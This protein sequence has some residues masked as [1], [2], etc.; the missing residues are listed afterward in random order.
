M[1]G[2]L[3]LLSRDANI[4][5]T[6]N[7]PTVHIK[8]YPGYGLRSATGQ[9]KIYISGV[10]WHGPVVF[11]RRQKMLIKMLGGVM[12]ASAE[13]LECE[14]FL[15]R[16]TPFMAEC[17]TKE[18]VSVE[19]GDQRIDLKKKTKRNGRF[20]GWLT[21]EHDLIQSLQKQHGDSSPI[22]F[23]AKVVGD[24]AC[25]S[26]VIHL[27]PSNGV[28]IISDI[29][30]TIKESDVT[31][32]R[33]LLNNTFLREFESVQGMAETYRHWAEGGTCF[34]YVSSS[35]WQLFTSLDELKSVHQ[36]PVGTM[37]LRN[38]RLRDQLLKKVIIRR[39]GKR[40]A[41]ERLI[42]NLP[43]RRYVLIGDSGEKDPEI[44]RK[45]CRKHPNSVAAVFIRDLVDRPMESERWQKLK[46]ELPHGV[47]ELFHNGDDLR[48]KAEPVFAALAD[49]VVATARVMK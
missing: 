11:N 7:N 8:A 40:A 5:N 19:L 39:Q 18:R 21:V 37:H 38:F 1:V 43:L 12:Q 17:D 20:Q 36:F 6:A 27:L 46:D 47:C 33:E 48:E 41:I 31:N 35:P 4:S 16:V 44:Y 25:S 49:H 42:K 28:S 14:T 9:W 30:D 10:V 2:N 26:C 29:D 23:S 24:D 22:P 13:E 32:K 15:N 3:C 34:H 45:I